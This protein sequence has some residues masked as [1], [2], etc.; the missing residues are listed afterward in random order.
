MKGKFGDIIK[1]VGS[2]L[3]IGG[4]IVATFLYGNR[5]RVEQARRD[6]EIRRQQEE[7]AAQEQA[8]QQ[9]QVSVQNPTPSQQVTVNNPPA[10]P[11]P[12]SVGQQVGVGGGQIP[13]TGG[14]LAL[15]LPAVTILE[16]G[17]RVRRS[18]RA[19]RQAL[20]A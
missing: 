18:K 3:I 19:L 10:A 8:T 2:V 20:S 9:P 1:T 11:A 13:A 15:A 17:R 6:A 7:K 14:E 4:I 12:N 5:Q 16:L